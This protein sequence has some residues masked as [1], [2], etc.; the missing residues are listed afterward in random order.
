MTIITP[1]GAGG[2]PEEILLVAE[3]HFDRML[4]RAEEV[5]TSLEAEDTGATKEAGQRIRDL[6]KAVQTALDERVKLEKLRKQRAGIVHEYALDFDAA[7]DE[8]G[9]R[10]ARLRAV[11]DSGTISE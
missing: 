3:K 1:V 7:R 8:I 11:A 9:R 4:R 5:I 2:G 10:M 6:S